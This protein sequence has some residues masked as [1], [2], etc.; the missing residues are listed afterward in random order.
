MATFASTAV[1]D[2][3]AGGQ[4]LFRNFVFISS[5]VVIEPDG[6]FLKQRL[7]APVKDI[8]KALSITCSLRNWPFS[9]KLSLSSNLGLA[10]PD[11]QS[12]WV[13]LMYCSMV[14]A[15][16]FTTSS[17]EYS[18]KSKNR[19][20][21]GDLDSSRLSVLRSFLD[22][23]NSCSGSLKGVNSSFGLKQWYVVPTGRVK[24]PADRY[25]VPTGKDNVIVSTGRSKVI[26]AGRTILVL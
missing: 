22:D 18:S 23:Q 5:Q 15:I 6:L 20:N 19:L 26:P 11:P 1:I 16:V 13:L 8:G 7:T 14:S 17:S 10:I 25:V 9:S 21:A 3:R 12:A 4:Y 24:V 2:V